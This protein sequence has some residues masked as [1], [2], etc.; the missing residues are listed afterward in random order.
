MSTSSNNTLTVNFHNLTIEVVLNR[1]SID[2]H[3]GGIGLVYCNH[4]SQYADQTI[5]HFYNCTF[6]TKMFAAYVGTASSSSIN[7]SDALF[8]CDNPF[9]YLTFTSCIFNTEFYRLH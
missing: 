5:T 4:P 2:C 7:Y 6:N 9:H 8:T 3:G 1:N